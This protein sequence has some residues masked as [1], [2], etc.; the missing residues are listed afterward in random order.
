MKVLCCLN[1][2]VVSSVALN[3]LLPWLKGHDVHVALSTRIGGSASTASE[4]P[5]RQELRVAEQL[6]AL[7]VVFPLIEQAA[8]PDNGRYLTFNEL[9]RLREIPVTPLSGR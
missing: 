8:H 5:P 7:D 9:T 2:D 3:L 1:A 6:L 4:P